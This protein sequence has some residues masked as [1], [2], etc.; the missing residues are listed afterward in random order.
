MIEVQEPSDWYVLAEYASFGV[1]EEDA[2]Q[3]RGW[4]QGLSC[5][6][7][8]T[9]STTEDMQAAYKQQI[10]ILRQSGD[11]YERQLISTDYADF[12]GASQLV[13]NGSLSMPGS[14][15][16]V[17]ITDSGRGQVVTEGGT[18]PI[19]RGTTFVVP[20]GTGEY[21]VQSAAGSEL[22]VTICFPP[23]S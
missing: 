6:D 10:S 20:A 16:C 8:R 23:Q 4:E 5:F 21:E 9:F 19:Q 12:F 7:Y 1:P 2:H 14:T 18:L 11:S 22:Q 17:G 3:G 15:L 13:V